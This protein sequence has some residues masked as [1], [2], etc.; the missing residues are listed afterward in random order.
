MA[1]NIEWTNEANGNP[2][3]TVDT[4]APTVALTVPA[5]LATGVVAAQ[6]IVITFS[7]RMDTASVTYSV[8]PDPGNLNAVWSV[9]DTV[10]TVSHDPFAQLTV[11]NVSVTAA[12]D[13]TGNNMIPGAVPNPWEFTTG[14]FE[15]PTADAGADQTVNEDIVVT[16]NGTLSADNVGIA[17]YTWTFNDSISD[18]TLYGV[19]PVHIFA[20]PGNYTV[21][22]NVTDSVGNS[23]T[24]TMWVLVLDVTP[25][26]ANAGANQT[27]N[28]G[29]TVTF[30]GSASTDNVGIVNY[31]WVF[32]DGITNITLYGVSPAH[33][34]T[35]VGVFTATLTVRDSAGLTGNDTMAVEVLDSTA[36]VA[37]AGIDQTVNESSIV[38]FNG[39]A[40]TD[41]IGITNYTWTFNDGAA[42][43]ALYGIAPTHLFA[44]PGVYTVTLN[45]TD[46]ESNWGLDTMTVTVLDTTPPTANAGV[47]QTV[48]EGATVTFNGAASSDNVGIVNYTWT[49]F[50]GAA[51][52]T[53]YSAGPAHQ[54]NVV[55]IYD[56]TLT[57]RDAAGYAGNDTMRVT[58]LDSTAPIANAG[59]D[60]TVN[61]STIV[62]FNG[63]ASLDNIG[64]VNYTWTFNDGAA[65]IVLYGPGPTHLFAIPGIYTVTLNVTDSE[66]NWNTDTMIVTVIDITLPTAEAGN[67][68]TVNEGTTVTFDGSVSSDNVGVVNYTWT[69]YDGAANITLYGAGPAHQFNVVGIYTVTLTVRD[70]AGNADNDTMIVTVLDITLPTANAGPD[71]TVSEDTLMAFD[72]TASTDNVGIVNYTW[73]FTDG[74]AVTLWGATPG[75][76]FTAP[77]IYAVTLTVRDAAGNSDTDTMTVTV[78]DITGPTSNAGA[79]ATIDEGDLLIF[80]GSASTDNIGIVNYT[81]TFT[82]GTPVALWGINPFYQFLNVGIFVV[83]LNVTDNEDNWDLDTMVV[84]VRDITEP[85]ARAGPD[86]TVNEDANVN[87]N[88]SASTD[89]IGIVNYTW[90]LVDGTQVYLW[91]VSPVYIFSTPGIYLIA[92]TVIDAAGN[93]DTDTLTVTVNDITLPTANAG[94][95]QTVI[96]GATVTFDG[97]ASADNV[98]VV[99]YT[100][101]FTDGTPVTLWGTGP[102]H[103]FNTIGV[104]TVTLTVRD[105]AG[106]S[107]TD[108]MTVTVTDATPPT[109]NAGIDR[110][111]NQGGNVAFDGT[112]STDNIGV[113]NYTWTFT[114][115]TPVTLWEATPGHIFNSAGT[116]TVT[117]TVR[118]AAGNSD[119]D[120]MTVT[121]TDNTA[122]SANAGADQ[123]VSAGTTVTFDGSASTDNVGVVNF[124]WTFTDGASVT[125]YGLAPDYQFNNAG[126]ITVTLTVSDATGNTDNDTMTVTVQIFTVDYIRI[127]TTST[128]GVAVGATVMTADQTLTVWAIGYSNIGGRLGPVNVIWSTAGTLDLQTGNLDNFAFSP[129]HAVTNGVIIASYGMLTAVTGLITVNPGTTVGYNIT[130]APSTLSAGET[131][132]FQTFGYDQ[133]WNPTGP[134]TVTWSISAPGID[135]GASNGTI[136]SSG[137]F[138]PVITADWTIT[139]THALGD[140]TDMI[141]VVPGA[142]AYILV[143]PYYS[144]ADAG[145]ATALAISGF[146]AYGNDID[147][148]T[149]ATVWY[150]DGTIQ[151]SGSIT[152]NTAGNHTVFANYYGFLGIAYINVSA[153]AGNRIV[154][155]QT[156]VSITADQTFTFSVSILDAFGNTVTG[157]LPAITWRAGN[158]TVVNGL[159]TPWSSGTWTVYA[160]AT[161]YTGGTATI[162]VTSGSVTRIVISPSGSTGTRA[163]DDISAGQS[164][165]FTVSALDQRENLVSVPLAYL[166]W[167]TTAGTVSNGF[168][169]ALTNL[170]GAQVLSGILSVVYDDG[171]T[172][173]TSTE[174]INITVGDLHHIIIESTDEVS[175]NEYLEFA[176][177]GYDLYGNIITGLTFT[178]G[179][180]GDVGDIGSD[181]VFHGTERGMGTVTATSGGITGSMPVFVSEP[182]GIFANW[183]WLVIILFIV[184]IILVVLLIIGRRKEVVVVREEEPEEDIPEEEEPEAMEEEISEEPEEEP[185]MEDIPEDIISE[186][187]PSEP[188]AEGMSEVPDEF[189]EPMADLEKE[190]DFAE[191]EEEEIPPEKKGPEITPA[192]LKAQLAE[193]M[194]VDRCEKMLSAAVVLP[195]DKERL[196]T[197]IAGGISAQ[198]FTAEVEKAIER[199]KKREKEKDVT[200]DEKASILEDELVAELAELEGQL[201]GDS[202]EDLEDQI[203]KEIEDLEDM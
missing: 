132:L 18:V 168:F 165:L 113:T 84:T 10:L 186:D 29:A 134:V 57:V 92:L 178:W 4:V 58:V 181:G 60:Q 195:E 104:F 203:L 39:S 94:P 35:A 183:L 30:D 133:E 93:S 170:N 119:T 6:D 64:I 101:T 76:N 69:F 38:T 73:T 79:D 201:D 184:V 16:F 68:Q 103:Q 74:V 155:A 85:I 40:S 24:D 48:N 7:E 173:V 82:D 139:A 100:W 32:F 15:A 88:G 11:Y 150:L 161:G 36:P 149:G 110:I 98:G 97:S 63:S 9:N 55:G 189:N 196:R 124:T 200:A 62:T 167:T 65:N 140:R 169:T 198:D 49:F 41:N 197:L 171:M 27:V 137:L 146:D 180:A 172:V 50:D 109:A 190:L 83:T 144:V 43:I 128:S 159:F 111:I 99:N 46:S 194:R 135:A 157:T 114:D 5:A 158:G 115:G 37:N 77:G 185:E 108:T 86:Q 106:N 175:L 44:I 13:P 3:I 20:Q 1:Q 154:I 23:D 87:F 192:K 153:S 176:A 34:F 8:T 14:D 78:N 143:N 145:D 136:S 202:E 138:M 130:A 80:D 89:N 131:F 90:S 187:I 177:S 127:E 160:N 61:E 95:D 26:T 2:I 102:S 96:Q 193:E 142:L 52:I 71:L 31:T 70:A 148:L 72:G 42:N 147:T 164:R 25:P 174:N 152:S 199:R 141:S 125:L 21:T 116:F 188:V 123:S 91:G 118:D 163:L 22:L 162:T 47:N 182:A 67:N 107:D 56:I 112:A 156:G 59:P 45:V 120:T 19:A 81:W 117:L 151:A 179:T 53:L 66:S 75:Y 17:N 166:E 191:L 54:F 28:E 33:Q 122:P 126:T 51:N 12:R 129:V 105:A 121:V